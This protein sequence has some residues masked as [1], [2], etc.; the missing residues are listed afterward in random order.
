MNS[1]QDSSTLHRYPVLE[2]R[3]DDLARASD[4][5]ALLEKQNGERSGEHSQERATR[6]GNRKEVT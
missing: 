5:E 3:D 1:Q 2:G 6:Q 4:R